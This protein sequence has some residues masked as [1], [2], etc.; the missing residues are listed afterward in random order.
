MAPDFTSQLFQ[1]KFFVFL[2]FLPLL[3][4]LSMSVILRKFLGT[5]YKQGKSG[6]QHNA[7]THL[8]FIAS[9]EL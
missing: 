7:P 2:T 3:P 5:W 4:T 8:E 6:M 9:L 1:K